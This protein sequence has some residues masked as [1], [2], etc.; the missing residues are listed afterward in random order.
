M[1]IS[2]G[3]SQPTVSKIAFDWQRWHVFYPPPYLSYKKFPDS[4]HFFR[5]FALFIDEGSKTAWKPANPF[6][7]AH[8]PTA[9]RRWRRRF[10]SRRF[11]EKPENTSENSEACVQLS[12]PY[13]HGLLVEF[14]TFSKPSCSESEKYGVSKK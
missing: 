14:D 13:N 10:L 5:D 12:I 1:R 6:V 8:A 2:H 3:I 4:A 7:Y 9:S 11:Y